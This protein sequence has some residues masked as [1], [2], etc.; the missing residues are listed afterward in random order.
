MF[1]VLEFVAFI[2][3]M[4][5]MASVRLWYE[6]DKPLIRGHYPHVGDLKSPSLG[7][8]VVRGPEELVVDLVG[9]R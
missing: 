7:L 4:W 8:P 3:V 2:E 1:W 5:L 6:Q 9:K